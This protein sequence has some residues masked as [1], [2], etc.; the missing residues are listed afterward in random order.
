MTTLGVSNV[1]FGLPNRGLLNQTYLIMALTQGLDAPIINPN[2]SIII[3]TINA[4]RVLVNEDKEASN[5]IKILFP[6]TSSLLYSSA[7]W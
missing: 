2:D 1:S 5:Y 7:I 4:F 6:S 3:D